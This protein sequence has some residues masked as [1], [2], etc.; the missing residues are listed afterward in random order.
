MFEFLVL[1]GLAVIGLWGAYAIFSLLVGT[2]IL[3]VAGLRGKL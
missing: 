1:L 3:L 2:I